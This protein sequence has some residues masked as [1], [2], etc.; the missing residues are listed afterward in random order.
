MEKQISTAWFDLVWVLVEK[1]ALDSLDLNTTALKGT[2]KHKAT[3]QEAV[4]DTLGLR[5]DCLS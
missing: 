2:L 1:T 3:D 5:T 4:F